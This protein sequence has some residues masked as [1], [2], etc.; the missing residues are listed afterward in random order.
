VAA[1]NAIVDEREGGAR[2]IL[3]AGGD[4]ERFGEATGPS[5]HYFDRVAR[6]RSYRV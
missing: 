3:E 4:R 2:A 6:G 5:T 1:I